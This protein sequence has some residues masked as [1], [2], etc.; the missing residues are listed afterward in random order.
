MKPE[1]D[2]VGWYQEYVNENNIFMTHY[3]SH[4]WG[5]EDGFLT[6]HLDDCY[7]CSQP[8]NLALGLIGNVYITRVQNILENCK[9]YLGDEILG[10]GFESGDKEHFS[11]YNDENYFVNFDHLMDLESHLHV[12]Q[13]YLAEF[14]KA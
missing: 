13:L 6:A 7:Y 14:L 2:L 8:G 4:S 5:C 12:T 3:L 11:I 9:P 10:A 1:F